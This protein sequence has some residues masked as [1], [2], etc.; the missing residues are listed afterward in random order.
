MMP[1]K[2]LS[3]V[4]LLALVALLVGSRAP[5]N[6]SANIYAGGQVGATAATPS[7]QLSL[8][9]FD[10][11]GSIYTY[12]LSFQMSNA[13][14]SGVVLSSTTNPATGTTTVLG[15]CADVNNYWTY[16]YFRLDI[17]SNASQVGLKI[18]SDTSSWNSAPA[19]AGTV[20]GYMLTW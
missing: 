15:Y 5:S 13:T 4:T 3:L 2:M 1:R 12:W 18:T 19:M 6:A 16:Y 17:K 14:Y 9:S 10:Y 20:G 8:Y 7:F 11:Y